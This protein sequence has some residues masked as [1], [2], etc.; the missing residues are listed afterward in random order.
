MSYDNTVH[1]YRPKRPR[2]TFNSEQLAELEAQFRLKPYL[3]GRER[4]VLAKRLQ[5]SETQV[6]VLKCVIF[7]AFTNDADQ[8]VV[9]KPSH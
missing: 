2:T 3:V 1:L 5:L 4:Q 9:S 7:K 8:G 6:V